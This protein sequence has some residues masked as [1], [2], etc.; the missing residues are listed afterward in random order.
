MPV[1]S[2]MLL[3]C[4]SISM[5]HRRTRASERWIPLVACGGRATLSNV[6]RGSMAEILRTL[7][8]WGRQTDVKPSRSVF[9]W[10]TPQC[11]HVTTSAT[12]HTQVS[13]RRCLPAG[14]RVCSTVGSSA[15]KFMT[16]GSI[17]PRDSSLAVS[18]QTE[19][20]RRESGRRSGAMEKRS[21]T[22]HLFL[23]RYSSYGMDSMG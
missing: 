16:L 18:S 6:G 19:G 7:G 9:R 1:R 12:L 2:S 17:R 20:A 8:D 21:D 15:R 23:L 13:V 3:A 10:R 22:V 5:L 14:E 11:V 4:W